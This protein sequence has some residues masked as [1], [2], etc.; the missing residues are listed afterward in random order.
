MILNCIFDERRPEKL[1][2]LEAEM[3]RQGISYTLWSADILPNV[4]ESI[5]ASHRKIVQYALDHNLPEIA[6]AED[7]VYFPHPEGWYMFLAK[8]PK[9]FDLYLAGCY[10]EV[11][12]PMTGWDE[13]PAHIVNKY[14]V[15][16]HCYIIRERYYRTFLNTDPT[17]HIDT[18]QKGVCKVCYPFAAIQRPGWSSN[19]QK[20]VNYNELLT[21]ADVYGGIPKL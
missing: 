14:P 9:N 13:S 20:I 1:P 11:V 5:N 15:G 19:N 21:D 8:K 2:L 18:A 16:L 6:I 10:S 17:V 4:V 12:H 7:D 3:L